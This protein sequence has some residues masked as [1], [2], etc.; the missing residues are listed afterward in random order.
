MTEISTNEVPSTDRTSGISIDGIGLHI[1]G[2]G[3]ET[4]VMI[5]GWP[6]TWQ[7]WERQ[8]LHFAP[9]FRCVRFTLPGFDIDGPRRGH[10]LD[11]VLGF[12]GRVL[13]AVSPDRPVTLMLHDWG[14]HFG[15]QYALRHPE[16]VARVIGIDVGDAHTR[17]FRRG[18]SLRH[19]LMAAG[20]QLWLMLAWRLG[21]LGLL[22]ISNRMTRWMARAMHCRS[23]PAR[24]GSCMNYPYDITWTGS[25]GGYRRLLP[26]E[27]PW[28]LFFAWGKKT[29]VTFHSRGWRER[30]AADPRH[31][32]MA[33]DCGH[34]VMRSRAAEFN[35]AVDDWLCGRR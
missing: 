13:D 8:V 25:H 28:P 10:S 34:W 11:E 20:Y 27:P 19:G 18:L 24:I 33:F 21:N 9:H 2:E 23:E 16:R 3:L 5:H 4:L 14:C 15:Y 12:I 29:P 26:L 30:L 7:L 31:V 17:E 1:D 22:G 6:D 35:Q 32:A